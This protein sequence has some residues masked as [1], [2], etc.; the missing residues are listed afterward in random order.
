MILANQHWNSDT[1]AQQYYFIRVYDLLDAEDDFD[2]DTLAD[3]ELD[4]NTLVVEPV[5]IYKS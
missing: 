5:T 4:C 2:W 1:N 3:D